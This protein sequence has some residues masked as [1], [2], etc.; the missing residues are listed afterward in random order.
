MAT[1]ASVQNPNF[2]SKGNMP[3]G[4]AA[5]IDQKW[6]PAK[7][8]EKQPVHELYTAKTAEETGK[9]NPAK[10]AMLKAKTNR[11]TTL[12]RKPTTK[13]SK[14]E[15]KVLIAARKEAKAKYAERSKLTKMDLVCKK[16]ALMR[17]KAKR[18]VMAK[19]CP[20]TMAPKPYKN[21]LEIIYSVGP[22]PKYTAISDKFRE[23]RKFAK[24]Q[25]K[26]TKTK[27][28]WKKEGSTFVHKPVEITYLY[29]V[30]EKPK[31]MSHDDTPVGSAKKSKKSP[32]KSMQ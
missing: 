25:L 3:G 26:A 8:A 12:K 4:G 2:A 14:E 32:K 27:P 5:P 22:K 23:Y 24:A 6:E 1:T 11:P 19:K 31:K 7:K 20:K 9:V 10:V 18:K 16:K 28:V 30:G 29:K 21:I 17:Q 15:K 13:L